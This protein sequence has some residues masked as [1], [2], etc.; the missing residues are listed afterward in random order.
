MMSQLLVIVDVHIHLVFNAKHFN[1][2]QFAKFA[3][4]LYIIVFLFVYFTKA[5]FIMVAYSTKKSELPTLNQ[6]M[7]TA[8]EAAIMPNLPRKSIKSPML[9]SAATR[10]ALLTKMLKACIKKIRQ[11][12]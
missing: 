5:Y 1:H 7:P 4:N 2:K 8:P 10:M 12:K 11:V 9:F 3:T 6:M